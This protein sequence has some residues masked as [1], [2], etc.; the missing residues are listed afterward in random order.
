MRAVAMI[1]AAAAALAASPAAGGPSVSLNG[2]NIDGVTG[3]RFENCSVTIDAEGNIHIEARGYTVRQLTPQAEGAAAPAP[4]AVP[5]PPPLLPQPQVASAAPAPAVAAPQ[6]TRRYFLATEQS[7]PDG[8]QYDIAVFINAKWIRELKSSEDQVIVEITKH[9]NPGSNRVVLA[10]TK[11][12]SGSRRSYSKDVTFRVIIGEGNAGG[13]HVMIDNPLV[14]M[15]RTA[16]ETD[17]VTEDFTL[18]AR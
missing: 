14:E 18:A 17:D 1:L 12:T 3:Q 8:T 2:V 4:K 13:D 11:R 5:L 15:K 10:A 7:R 9:L 6:L 16:A